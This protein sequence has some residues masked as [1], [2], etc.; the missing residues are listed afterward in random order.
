M[1]FDDSVAGIRGFLTIVKKYN[2]GSEEIV[3]KDHNMIVSGMGVS[4]S[5]MFSAPDDS[6]VNNFQIDRF[7]VGV[8]GNTS[9]VLTSS[10]NQLRSPLENLSDYGLGTNL[11]IE[12][13]EQ[14]VN[15]SIKI[16]PVAKIPK[17]KVNKV[18]NNK[19]RYTLILDEE[20]CND[21]VVN[22]N[23]A[24]INEIGMLV[25]NPTLN[26]DDRPVLVCYKNFSPVKK[27]RDF[28]LVF[29]WTIVTSE[30]EAVAINSNYTL[31][32]VR[33]YDGE[34]T[35]NPTGMYY[36]TGAL[37]DG[38]YAEFSET[39][40]T[41]TY[42]N[43]PFMQNDGDM[44]GRLLK[45]GDLFPDKF[46][47]LIPSG[48]TYTSNDFPL[49]VAFADFGQERSFTTT[50]SALA[51]ELNKRDCFG[52]I[53][54]GDSG[55]GNYSKAM[56]YS[57]FSKEALNHTKAI[58]RYLI[59]TYPIDKDRIYF[60]GFGTGGGQ[61]ASV[62]SL[63]LD[64]RPTGWYPASMIL[65]D[66]VL[67][68]TF[69]WW[70]FAPST[71]PS[72]SGTY[73]LP[74]N[75][76]MQPIAKSITYWCASSY[77]TFEEGGGN[78]PG[79]YH[80]RSY[81]YIPG[82]LTNDGVDG[83]KWKEVSGI[84]PDHKPFGF[85]EVSPIEFN[86]NT[87]TDL[88]LSGCYLMNLTHIPTYVQFNTNNPSGPP[89]TLPNLML[90]SF[91][92]G[93]THNPYNIQPFNKQYSS[94]FVDW[95]IHTSST[96]THNLS[97][98]NLQ[99]A[100]DY[101]FAKQRTPVYSGVT[102]VG[103]T[104]EYWGLSAFGYVQKAQDQASGYFG[105]GVPQIYEDFGMPASANLWPS[106]LSVMYWSKDT[107]ENSLTL[108]AT[109]LCQ[110]DSKSY[111]NMI[112][113]PDALGLDYGTSSSPLIIKKL[114]MQTNRDATGLTSS[115]SLAN[116]Y[117][118]PHPWIETWTSFLYPNQD[119]GGTPG[120]GGGS[121]LGGI[122]NVSFLTLV[123]YGNATILGWA[124]G[125]R[126]TSVIP[127]ETNQGIYNFEV[128]NPDSF[129][130]GKVPANFG[131]ISPDVYYSS[132]TPTVTG[133]GQ[134]T[135]ISRFRKNGEPFP[136]ETAWRFL[137]RWAISNPLQ[138]SLTIAKVD[139]TNGNLILMQRGMYLIYKP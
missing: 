106:G 98:I 58:V 95:E 41:V 88:W 64:P 110:D 2:D 91:L 107:N 39:E 94:L 138:G 139:K 122:R 68:N 92:L 78:K 71:L 9:E 54:L 25:K 103:R 19:V 111:Q 3:L 6:L 12:L 104:G 99:E 119:N 48:F 45:T 108:S 32:N 136:D 102:M 10:I 60:Y 5:E 14:I 83:P 123:G 22:G 35:T 105:Y 77:G 44:A 90:S 8:S 42:N 13:N 81:D 43:V 23:E 1:R 116:D 33:T 37:P 49:M 79:I 75:A 85:Y 4:L 121:R 46:Q 97:S 87:S 20:A 34:S 50:F 65:H 7:Q 63:Q 26:D 15:N 125:I 21:L 40:E 112:I 38:E 47:I 74:K 133:P 101:C 59:D 131:T 16:T 61:A 118:Y 84:T 52:V 70:Y 89:V 53:P 29:R 69:T 124:S 66:A 17:G 93:T 80:V 128:P 135:R 126:D 27:T 76:T 86:L 56:V 100:L 30:V 62:A 72:V 57:V 36:S 24:S 51:E 137:P 130:G 28:S 96:G 18:G 132:G 129:V 113:D 31:V 115:F 11:D 109:F 73:P 134:W 120:Y 82:V 67:S 55:V 127:I 114:F 117:E